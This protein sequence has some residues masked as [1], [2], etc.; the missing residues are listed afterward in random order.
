MGQKNTVSFFEWLRSWTF[1]KQ[2]H[3]TQPPPSWAGAG[4]DIDEGRT[5]TETERDLRRIQSQYDS[6]SGRFK[7]DKG[8]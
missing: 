5:M 1:S 4:P 2:P 6:K 3:D 7:D 8:R